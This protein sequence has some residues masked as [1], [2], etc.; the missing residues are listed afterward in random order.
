MLDII[1]AFVEAG[2][3]TPP[4]ADSA[5]PNEPEFNPPLRGLLVGEHNEDVTERLTIEAAREL[6]AP[7]I[8]DY[9]AQE[10]PDYILWLN[11]PFGVGKTHATAL[12][13]QMLADEGK[14]ILFAAPRKD[15]W[16][17]V[18]GLPHFDESKWMNW[19]ARK[20]GDAETGFGGNCLHEKAINVWMGRG[21]PAMPFCKQ[22]CRFD[23]INNGC[24]Y[25]AQKKRSEAIVFG[26]HAHLF[27][28][29]P[30]T[31]HVAII[32]ENPVNAALNKWAIPAR[33]IV[34]PQSDPFDRSSLTILLERVQLL[35]F[36]GERLEGKA[37]LDAL[38]GCDDVLS[39]LGS[40]AVSDM[41]K[42]MSPE[43]TSADEALNAPYAHVFELA[44]LLT[45][46]AEAYKAGQEYLSRVI[47][48]DD[49]LVLLLRHDVNKR[50]PEHLIIL[51]ATGNKHIYETIFER[52]VREVTLSVERKGKV[53]QVWDR[54]NNKYALFKD[55][56]TTV[57]AK[58]AKT[59]VDHITSQR[60]YE[61][62]GAFTFQDVKA[63]FEG[64]QTG[65]FGA[66]TGS[67]AFEGVDALFVVGAPMPDP[68][69][70]IANAKMVFKNRMQ[71]FDERWYSRDVPFQGTDVSYPL[72]GFWGD[73]DLQSLVE[74]YR[75]AKIMQAAER[76][77]TNIRDSHVWLLT[78]VPLKGYPP[79]ELLT[80]KDIIGS[81]DGINP[82]KWLEIVE[83]CKRIF[84]D[85]GMVNTKLIRDN[86]D[87]SLST[88][89]KYL[90]ALA[91]I[92]GWV[93]TLAPP[94]DRGR[95][96]KIAYWQGD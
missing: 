9:V 38:G 41:D 10:H 92:A 49:E 25:H 70:L 12:V 57:A 61:R 81:P 28:G 20:G 33:G 53:F 69:S 32:D 74:Q 76:A 89:N 27:L 23:Y 93:Q 86:F 63:V 75:D 68:Y 50:L 35:A 91:T 90:D 15:M 48:A 59:L 95:R 31:F 29:H 7:P 26:Q 34:P 87:V 14:R 18:T 79:D 96:A 80:I 21:H 85:E 77:R 19:E 4:I 94:K 37:L 71:A 73:L 51:D 22:I 16:H 13:A 78:N 56:Q 1:D 43:I 11:V 46:E 54:L 47:V 17:S 5:I 83:V 52:E 2:R 30:L 6:I 58:Q 36:R 40:V 60:N 55:G 24:A 8:L 39:L 62:V 3:H 66:E 65:H 64:Y 84:E 42:I 67:N 72:N 45:K 44:K 88:A 82:F